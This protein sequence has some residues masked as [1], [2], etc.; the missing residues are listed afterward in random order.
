VAGGDTWSHQGDRQLLVR[1]SVVVTGPVLMVQPVVAR[2]CLFCWIN[3][4][5]VPYKNTM[6]MFVC[7]P[8]SSITREYDIGNKPN[9]IHYVIHTQKIQKLSRNQVIQKWEISN[10]WNWDNTT[11]YRPDCRRDRG[12]RLV[13]PSHQPCD[14]TYPDT[15]PCPCYEPVQQFRY[16]FSIRLYYFQS[17][18]LCPHKNLCKPVFLH[19][20][21]MNGDEDDSR[22]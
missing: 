14:Q 10:S 2:M 18:T 6:E 16:Q 5:S 17:H 7:Y 3:A 8:D 12:S 1:Q 19:P 20:P 4:D 11:S 13:L 21:A 22:L 9:N 15:S